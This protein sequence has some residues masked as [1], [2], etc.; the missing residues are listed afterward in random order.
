MKLEEILKN[1]NVVDSWENRPQAFTGQK[2]D[3][4]TFIGP[5]SAAWRSGAYEKALRLEEQGM[6]PEDI[7]RKTG[8]GRGIDKKW[9]QEISDNHAELTLPYDEKIRRI[10]AGENVS[11]MGANYQEGPDILRNKLNHSTLYDAY[12]GIDNSFIDSY[13]GGTFDKDYLGVH[14]NRDEQDLDYYGKGLLNF[15]AG[16]GEDGDSS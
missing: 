3:E 7:W 5:N 15:A 1:N 8:T 16:F 2:V 4:A 12:P 14:F 6:S 13:P 9:R 10:N 11:D